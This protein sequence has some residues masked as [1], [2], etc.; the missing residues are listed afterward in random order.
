MWEGSR[1]KTPN[2]DVIR[3]SIPCFFTCEA[4]E[5]PHF[6]RMPPKTK[7]P[8]FKEPAPAKAAA[9]GGPAKAAPPA[10]GK[11]GRV[12][13]R[14]R[15]ESYKMYIIRVLKDMHPEAS[16]TREAVGVVNGFVN[17]LFMRIATDAGKIT[18]FAKR[19]TMTGREVGAAVAMILPEELAKI[20][21][22]EAERAVTIVQSAPKKTRQPKAAADAAKA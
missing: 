18:H 5:P 7:V 12:V 1:K 19:T 20:A 11:K 14:S 10:E 13:K 21:A 17:D 3:F 2:I 6:T 4:W 8:A 22:E 9:K 16:I 15:N